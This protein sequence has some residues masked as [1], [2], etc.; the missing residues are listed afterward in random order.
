MASERPLIG[1]PEI[2]SRQGI[3]AVDHCVGDCDLP[4]AR[5]NCGGCPDR[6]WP[7]YS[8]CVAWLQKFGTH[9]MSGASLVVWFE[10]KRKLVKLSPERATCYPRAVTWRLCLAPRWVWR[11]HQ[12]LGESR[13]PGGL[14][15]HWRNRRPCDLQR[16]LRAASSNH[17][18][19]LDSADRTDKRPR[20]SQ[21]RTPT[22]PAPNAGTTSSPIHAPNNNT[23]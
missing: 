8:V 10:A 2:R 5:H 11:R 14:P 7:T 4:A 16:L 18:S 20:T 19:T 15:W 22:A 21:H 17:Q 1:R 12:R 3:A 9:D 23:N 13:G 6:A